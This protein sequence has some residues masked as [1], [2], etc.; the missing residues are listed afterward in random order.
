MYKHQWVNGTEANLP[1][2]KVVCVGRN[3]VAHAKELNNPVPSVPLLFIKPTTTYQPFTGDIVLDAALGAHHYE[4]EIALL[5]GKQLDKHSTSVL[6]AVVGV[7]LA[8]DVTLRDEQDKLKKLGQPWERAKAYDGSCPITAFSP[9][10]S[11]EQL[12][13]NEVRFWLNNELK[14]VGHS[15]HMIFSYEKLLSDICQFCTLLPGDVILTGTP[16]G[17]G[18]LTNNAE[19]RLQLNEEKPFTALVRI[20]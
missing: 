16:E 17:V 3:Y 9:I 10:T 7:G 13:N 5:I 11:I 6:D 8:L 15:Q 4:A 2:G 14:Q 19:V 20:Q 12:K 1:A 18:K